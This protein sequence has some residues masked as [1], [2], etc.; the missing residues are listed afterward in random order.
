LLQIKILVIANTYLK[1]KFFS[2]LKY[3]QIHKCNYVGIDKDTPSGSIYIKKNSKKK[4][5]LFIKGQHSIQNNGTSHAH[6]SPSIL[7][8]ISLK[9][10]QIQLSPFLFKSSHIDKSSMNLQLSKFG[11]DP[12]LVDFHIFFSNLMIHNT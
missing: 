9:K 11:F 8:I 3:N 4:M 10:H 12:R 7:Y 2:F 5:V 1:I 6:F